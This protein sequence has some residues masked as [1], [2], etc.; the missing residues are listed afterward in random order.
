MT[1]KGLIISL[2]LCLSVNYGVC[3]AKEN[4][5]STEATVETTSEE[6]QQSATEATTTASE[7]E[8]SNNKTDVSNMSLNEFKTVIGE[9]SELY[10]NL[11]YDEVFGMMKNSL[12]KGEN[13]SL[14]DA[15]SMSGG[16]TIPDNF[17]YDLSDCGLSGSLDTTKLNFEY[18][19]LVNGMDTDYTSSDLKSQSHGA[20]DLFNSNYGNL[21]SSLKVSNASLPKNFSMKELTKSNNAALN[22]TYSSAY[23]DKNFASVRGSIDVSG[24]F[25]QAA[26]GVKSDNPASSADLSSM[27]QDASTSYKAN[28]NKKK[29]NAKNYSEANLQ[30][31]LKNQ[32]DTR[33]YVD[34]YYVDNYGNLITP[35]TSVD[36]N[37]NYDGHDRNSQFEKENA[38]EYNVYI[39]PSENIKGNHL[40]NK[41]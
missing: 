27:I 33:N 26:S 5:L 8:A 11:S 28:A 16:L 31:A 9:E 13:I 2:A 7:Y 41:Q 38:K 15:F 34:S 32:I 17:M 25:G 6:V 14:A 40:K 37:G 36:S 30:N 3:S 29:N 18:A 39:A 24:I 23:K 20:V 4:T 21:A 35:N 19:N 12:N 22:T 10:G 1:R